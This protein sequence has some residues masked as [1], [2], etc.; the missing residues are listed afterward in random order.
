MGIYC[1]LS[2]RPD[3]SY[4]GVDLQNKWGR[5]Y[6][7]RVWPDC[8]VRVFADRGI[9]AAND[10]HRPEYEALRAAVRAGQIGH[11]WAVEQTR[12]ER[13]EVQW[14]E[15]AAELDAAGITE[16]HTDRDGIVRVRDEVAGI[17]AVLAAAEVRKLKRRVNDKLDELAAIGRP[18]GGRYFGYRRVVDD[19]GV[20]TLEVVPEQA[21]AI[22]WAADAVLSGWSLTSIGRRLNQD[23]HRGALGGLWGVSSVRQMLVSPAVAGL[24]VH[25]GVIVGPGNWSPILATDVWQAV[26]AKLAKPR[27]VVGADGT[28]HHIPADRLGHAP[29]RKYLLTGGLAVCGVC[30]SALVGS[31]KQDRSRVKAPYLSCTRSSGGRGCIGIQLH[32]TEDYVRDRLFT[33]L[34]K[35]EFLAAVAADDHMQQRDELAAKLSVVDSDRAELAREWGAGGLRMAEWREARTELDQRERKLRAELAAIPAPRAQVDIGDVRA[36]WPAMTLE[37]RRE[38]LRMF[39]ARVVINRKPAGAP[40]VFDAERRVAIQWRTL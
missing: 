26:R 10:D 13:R 29:P 35:P 23:G 3:G 2:P 9:S 36:A 4:E 21:E 1:R 8:P 30:G 28:T 32:P 31:T 34:D 15:L 39:I 40:R 17:K 38:L 16:V 19:Q 6:A 11:V 7:A 12:L 24:R 25:R 20:P 27:S 5:S 14:F 22:R 33:E 37:E 18:A